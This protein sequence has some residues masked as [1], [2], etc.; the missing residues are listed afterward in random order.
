M[1]KNPPTTAVRTSHAITIKVNG[2]TVGMING[3]NP[4]QGRTVTPIFEVGVDTSG[5]PVECMPGNVTGLTIS[6]SRYDVYTLQMERAF[7]TADLTMLSRQSEPFSVIESWTAPDGSQER[8]IYDGCWFTSLGRGL[9]SDGDRL[10]NVNATL[11]YTKKMK[12]IGITA[13]LVK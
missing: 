2:T 8:Y 9:R 5:I 1:A 4:T 6:I 10:V 12:V 3:W 13:G 11:M 7:G